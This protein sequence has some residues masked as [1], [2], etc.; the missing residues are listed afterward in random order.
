MSKAYSLKDIFPL[1]D[2]QR[3][4]KKHLQRMKKSGR[5]SILT[6]N[7]KAEAVVVDASVFEK[8]RDRLD[9]IDQVE[10]LRTAIQEAEAG[11][12]VSNVDA[13]AAARAGLK[14]SARTS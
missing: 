13:F 5:P 3:N 6:V 8:M 7:G 1:S 14:S 2:F 9:H 12:L 10:R 11:I 4:T